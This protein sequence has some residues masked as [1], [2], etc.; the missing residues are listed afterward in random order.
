MK[1]CT[2]IAAVAALVAIF[3]SPTALAREDLS[4]F[5][6]KYARENVDQSRVLTN[7]SWHMAGEKHRRVAQSYEVAST[8]KST[9]AAFKSDEVACARAFMSA[10]IQL[11][12]R[13]RNLG[14]DGVIDIKSHVDSRTFDEGDIFGCKAGNI[15]AHVSL[16]GTPV[17]FK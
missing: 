1:S 14:G 10:I 9:N 13:A 8:T 17:K 12:T 11:Q 4:T 15:V 2:R 3:V 7:I 16:T 5:T 6:V